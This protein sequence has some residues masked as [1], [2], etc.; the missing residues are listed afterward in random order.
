[1][2]ADVKTGAP[3]CK[4]L[5]FLILSIDSKGCYWKIMTSGINIQIEICGGIECFE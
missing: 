2:D 5:L 1:M 3:M 4:P